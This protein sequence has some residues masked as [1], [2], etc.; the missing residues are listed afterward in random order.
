MRQAPLYLAGAAA[1]TSVVSITYSEILLGAAFLALLFFARDQWRLPP[2]VWPVIAWM[3]WTLV[4]LAASGHAQGGLPQVKKFYV[5]LM[6][7]VVYSALRTLPQIRVVTLAWV[8]G[9]TLS[10]LWGFGQFV[11]MYRSTRTYFYFAYV[12]GNRITGFVDHWMTFSALLMMTLLMGGA[13]L[14]YSDGKRPSRWLIP[15]LVIIG[16]GVLL[17]FTRSMWVGTVAGA[18]WLLW[19]K[20]KWL[21]VAVPLLIG[22][23]L[24]VNP[25][26]RDRTLS[27]IRPQY[28]VLDSRAHRAALRRVGWEMIRAHPI[29]GVGPEQVGPQFMQYYPADLPHPFPVAWYKEHLHNIYIHYAAERGLP[30]LGILLWLFA[31]VLFDFWTTLRSLPVESEARW[32]LHGAIASVIAVMLSGWTELTLGHSQVLEMFLAVLACGYIAVHSTRSHL[33]K[34]NR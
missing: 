25:Q 29:V 33:H 7:F 12:N 32:V 27:G 8:A 17:A 11:Q 22:I 21:V 31:R 9:A 30:A 3:A 14:L 24:L 13:M 19:W 23:I 15:A 16:A 6:L 1:A 2:V 18:L 34:V 4:S 28:N 10:A 20:N 5:W 26:V